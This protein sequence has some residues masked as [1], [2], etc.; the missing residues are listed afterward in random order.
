MTEYKRWWPYLRYSKPD[1][2]QNIFSSEIIFPSRTVPPKTCLLLPYPRPPHLL[3]RLIV[4]T[5]IHA[6]IPRNKNCS[7]ARSWS[8]FNIWFFW[9][10]F[11]R[12][13]RSV[14]CRIL[15]QV[16][17]F[18]RNLRSVPCRI[19]Y[20]VQNLNFIFCVVLVHS[21]ISGM[22]TLYVHNLNS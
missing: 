12:N 18:G 13:L 8:T 2:S 20:Q 11:G 5:G 19:L 9:I 17:N 21:Q 16:Q 14:P 7:H 3:L 1:I 4:Q 10:N 22:L 6:N 15:Y